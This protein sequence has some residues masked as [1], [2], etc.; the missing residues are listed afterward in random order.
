MPFVTPR[1]QLALALSGANILLASATAGSNLGGGGTA[2]AL[3]PIFVT[4]VTAG[5]TGVV[6]RVQASQSAA[7]GTWVVL[8][9]YKSS[10]TTKALA[11]SV[12]LSPAQ[13]NSSYEGLVC[14]A[15]GLW[16][17]VQVTAQATGANGGSGD[18]CG[19]WMETR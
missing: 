11:A 19:A 16:P 9:V 10:D 13:G 18:L 3:L 1:E 8:P 7:T 4:R 5:L 15:A 14:D 12:T 2:T 17:F 6:F